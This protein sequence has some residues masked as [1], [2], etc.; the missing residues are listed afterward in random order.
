LGDVRGFFQIPPQL[1]YGLI[2]VLVGFAIGWQSLGTPEGFRGGRGKEEALVPRQQVIKTLVIA[3]LYVAL[4]A[5]PY[6][7]RRGIGSI[8]DS[9][10]L[11]WMGVFL[12]AI[13]IG[14]VFWSGMALG[15]LYSGDVTLQEDHQLISN[16]PYQLIRH[17]RY[18]G[19]ALFGFGISFIFNCWIGLLASFLFIMLILFRIKDEEV[20]MSQAFGLEW[21]QYCSKSKKLIPF[22]Y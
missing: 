7:S 8:S 22:I 3:M 20:L 5:L 11:R 1:A 16:G 17:P 2:V 9:V 4:L 21:E 13:G 14:L 19:G 15:R 18:A 10:T 6:A 12:F